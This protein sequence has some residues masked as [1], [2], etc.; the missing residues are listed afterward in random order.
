MMTRERLGLAALEKTDGAFSALPW[1]ELFE[2][3]RAI[4]L[5]Q[6]CCAWHGDWRCE[7]VG[8]MDLLMGVDYSEACRG[9]M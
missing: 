5:F 2:S 6:K 4:P 1:N 9:C 8:V 7:G 3:D